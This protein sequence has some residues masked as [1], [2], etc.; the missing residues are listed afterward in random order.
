MTLDDLLADLRAALGDLYGD[1]LVRLVLY[2]SQARGDTHAESDVDVL[3]VLDG[4]VQPGREIR[5]MSDVRTR[6][7][8]QY[9][10]ALSLLP[11]SNDAYEQESSRW[12]ANAR[13]EG[14]SV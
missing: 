6:L 5:R 1:R 8:L 13:R 10:K 2:G 3:V 4:D 9:G 12:V 7:G 14:R 11:V